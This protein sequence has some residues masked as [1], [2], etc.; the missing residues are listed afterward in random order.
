MA[1]IKAINPSVLAGQGGGGSFS[2]TVPNPAPGVGPQG[3]DA[4]GNLSTQINPGPASVNE[5][6]TRPAPTSGDLLPNG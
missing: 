4:D 3:G 6:G 1:Q 5:G 2:V